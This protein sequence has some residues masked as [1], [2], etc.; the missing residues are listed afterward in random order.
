MYIDGH[1]H[2]RDEEWAYKETVAHALEVA[3]DSK[4]SGIFDII[5]NPTPVTTRQRVLDR[6]VLAKEADSPVF[7][8][9]HIL[10]TKNP[11]QIREAVETHKEFF[12]RSYK[13]RLGVVGVKMFAGKSVGDLTI[14]DPEEQ[15]EV[16]RQ[17]V[18]QGYKGVLV[19][20]CEKGSEMYPELWNTSRPETHCDARPEKAEF[21]SIKDQF[22]FALKTKY[23]GRIHIAHVSSPKSVNLIYSYNQLLQVSCGATPHH[24][25]LN[26]KSQ[27]GIEYKV[28]PPL[29]PL[30]S[31]KLLLEQFK[32]GMI[33]TLE[34]DHAPHTLEEKL[35]G[36]GMSGIPGLS[37]WPFFID[38]LK[39]KGVNGY[40]IKKV[41]FENVNKIFGTQIQR[42]NFPFK[43]HVGEYAFEPY[44]NLK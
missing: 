13:D 8:G 28:N 12:P 43:S 29:R 36:D 38:I 15:K 22:D 21:E 18:K 6:F 25:L 33:D 37:S 10:L 1:V 17:L 7:Y 41:G 34:T 35:K 9:V 3:R 39:E 40:L 11:D 14:G 5:N 42:I 4:L 20:H 23:P 19:V 2:C 30:S 26:N 16:Y 44:R 24:L 31:Q 32:I 27:N